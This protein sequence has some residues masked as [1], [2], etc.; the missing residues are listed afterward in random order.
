MTCADCGL[1]IRVNSP[2]VHG[3]DWRCWNCLP[4]AREYLRL[5]V[6]PEPGPRRMLLTAYRAHRWVLRSPVRTVR[7]RE[8][9]P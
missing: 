2:C 3:G 5:P 1:P 9:A 6:A 7:R 4:A 8:K